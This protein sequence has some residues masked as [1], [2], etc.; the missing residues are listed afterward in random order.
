MGIRMD[1]PS[2]PNR[3]IIVTRTQ[4]LLTILLLALSACQERTDIDLSSMTD[5]ERQAVESLAWL[6]QANAEQDAQVAIAYNDLRLLGMPGR[7]RNLPGV[8]PGEVDEVAKHCGIRYLEGVSDI[9]LGETH[10]QLLQ[11][12]SEY[13]ARYNRIMLSHCFDGNP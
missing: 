2:H 13:A 10:R 5:K 8:A 11:A 3:E 12:V 9:V 1:R 4:Q 6:H 7:V